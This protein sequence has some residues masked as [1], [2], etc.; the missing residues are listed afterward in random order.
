MNIINI[1][2]NR[3]FYFNIYT[4][5]AILVLVLISCNDDNSTNNSSE[6]IK[7]GALLPLTGTGSSAGESMLTAIE[8]AVKEKNEEL[9]EKTKIELITYDTETNPQTALDK[10]KIL[11]SLGV[12]FVVGP[13]SSAEL[14]YISSYA[15]E[16]NMILISPSSVSISLAIKNDNIF[17]LATNDYQQVNAVSKYLEKLE[18][19][20]VSAINR[21]DIWGN[22]LYEEL[23]N[24]SSNFNFKIDNQ[25]KY[26]VN[27]QDFSTIANNIEKNINIIFST[28]TNYKQ[29][30]V[31]LAS[32]NEGT[33]ILYS[34]SNK[35]SA[36][37]V[38]WI[39]TSAFALN[40]TILANSSA[41]DFAV[42][43]NFTCPVYTPIENSNYEPIRNKI[44]STIN[45]EPETYAYTAYDAINVAYNSAIKISQNQ[46]LKANDAVV[47]YCNSQSGI[48]GPLELDEYG[49]R[50]MGDYNFWQLRTNSSNK[51]WFI[52]YKYISK[53]NEL[54]EID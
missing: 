46:S 48:T 9:N 12:T 13:Y 36:Q 1:I 37:K 44:K 19:Q 2:K 38:N 22:S 41:Y 33:D 43:T 35:L 28:N 42:K 29:I 52:K 50:K 24:K 54:K 40:S 15:N 5:F 20:K 17:R 10:I 49:D 34:V 6:K 53:T 7:I 47:Q 45:R 3:N 21:N 23:N 18:I 16:N 27:T 30:A 26:E 51:E 25:L 8:L 11:K 4:I 31:Y 14:D 39:G 32:F